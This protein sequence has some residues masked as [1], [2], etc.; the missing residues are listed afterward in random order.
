MRSRV[1]KYGAVV[2]LLMSV[3]TA[4]PAPPQATP[5][6]ANTGPVSSPSESPA[7]SEAVPTHADPLRDK[8]NS[9]NSAYGGE[10]FSYE[11]PGDMEISE[12][13][14][15]LT[16]QV[17]NYLSGYH[18][19]FSF[20]ITDYE[21]VPTSDTDWEI[22]WDEEEE[23]WEAWPVVKIAWT[24]WYGVE[25]TMP[26]DQELVLVGDTDGGLG[27]VKITEEND[28]YTLTHWPV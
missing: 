25:G 8:H 9:M 23:C 27:R 21:I 22:T 7:A 4:C 26:E 2:L 10:V 5:S 18:E 16:G 15:Q 12:I 1:T 6:P 3:L 14:Y 24:G 11:P 13:A 17:M 20:Q 19:D 28:V